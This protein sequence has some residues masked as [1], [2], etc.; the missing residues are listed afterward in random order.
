VICSI[1]LLTR[2]RFFWLLG[3]VLGLVGTIIAATGLAIR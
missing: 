1:A 2:K 3:S